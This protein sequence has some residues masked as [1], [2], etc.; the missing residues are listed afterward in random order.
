MDAHRLPPLVPTLPHP[1]PPPPGRVGARGV[2]D[3][4]GRA[5]ALSAASSADAGAIV[6]RCATAVGD[7]TQTAGGVRAR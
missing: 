4:T 3:A 5:L 2:G 1:Q 7:R 6:M